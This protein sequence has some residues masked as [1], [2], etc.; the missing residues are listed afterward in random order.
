MLQR[1]RE[2]ETVQPSA[3]IEPRV[4]PG[5]GT[6]VFLRGT[7]DVRHAGELQ[8]TLDAA[9]LAHPPVTVDLSGVSSLDGSIVR[10]LAA[11]SEDF[12]EGLT[13]RGLGSDRPNAFELTQVE[14][15]ISG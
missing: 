5:E 3:S 12:V 9:H 2:G 13:V 6:L 15:F 7:L 1:Y 8:A 10:V 4:V 11:A 14:H